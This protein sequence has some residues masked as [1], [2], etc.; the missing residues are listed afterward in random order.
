MAKIK[1]LVVD[2]SVLLYDKTSIHSFNGNTVVLPMVVLDELDKFKDKPGILGE[3]ARYVNRFL[4]DLRSV[5][6]LH[7]GIF[8]EEYNQTIKILTKSHDCPADLDVDS[9]DNKIISAALYLNRTQD[10]PIKV[11]TKD[12]N[13]RVK[14]DAL[15]LSAEDYYKDSLNEDHEMFSGVE[16]IEV[17]DAFIDD[18]FENET[19]EYESSTFENTFVI[20]N[21][22]SQGKSALG[23]FSKNNIDLIRST[24]EIAGIQPRNKEQTF[25][26]TALN[27][28][29]IPLVSL[30]GL[31]GSGKTYLALMVGLEHV[32][33]GN[34]ERLVVTRNI[35]PVGRDLGYLPGDVN[36]KMAPWLAPLMDNFRHHFKDKS[37]FELMMEK[38]TIEIAPLSYIRGRTFNNSYII[39]DEAQNATIHELKTIITRIGENSKMVLMGDTGQIDTPYINERS[40]GLSIVVEKFK[41]S[42]LSAHVHLQRGERS[43]LATYASNV[44]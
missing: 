11:I 23:I 19:V 41:P 32:L 25:A 9:N 2:T 33:S 39:V 5:G 40:N 22:P 42:I 10:E 12:I 36:E 24:K 29:D 3:S 6:K 15:G 27:N 13:L 16:N 31:A 14:C 26:L 38:G 30:T 35:E 28:R 44:L 34:Y 21:G 8:I 1:L 18:L 37:Y 4:D 43:E 17:D 7:D 20:C